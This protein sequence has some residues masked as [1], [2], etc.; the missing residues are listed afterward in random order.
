MLGNVKHVISLITFIT[1]RRNVY[2][3]N[4]LS[5]NWVIIWFCVGRRC[6]GLFVESVEMLILF[7]IVLVWQLSKLIL[8][9]VEYCTT[10]QVATTSD[11]LL[12]PD[13]TAVN[14]SLNSTSVVYPS[15]I[16]SSV[17]SSRGHCL[18]LVHNLAR[19]NYGELRGFLP[20]KKLVADDSELSQSLKV[21]I[22][23]LW[24]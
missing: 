13:V 6:V 15:F 19:T 8:L 2:V 9:L 12:L 20:P 16:S 1:E 22:L 3:S 5:S 14:R 23:C 11:C 4:S 17:V 24:C 18:F 7:G 10:A 21:P